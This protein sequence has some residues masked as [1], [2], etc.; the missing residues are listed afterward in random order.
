MCVAIPA[1]VVSFD[2]PGFAMVDV[3]GVRQRACV[4]LLPDVRVGDYVIVHAGFALS[5]IDPEEAEA[6]L[7]LF[8][9]LQGLTHQRPDSEEHHDP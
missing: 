1:R 5:T 3:G 9:Q 2:E 6:T 7:E 4:E 8:R